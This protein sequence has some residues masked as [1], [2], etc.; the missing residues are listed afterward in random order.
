MQFRKLT[1]DIS[2]RKRECLNLAMGNQFQQFQLEELLKRLEDTKQVT[3]DLEEELTHYPSPKTPSPVNILTALSP[4]PISPPAVGSEVFTLSPEFDLLEEM[5]PPSEFLNI[6]EMSG[7]ESTPLM[8]RLRRPPSPQFRL[9]SSG[10]LGAVRPPSEMRYID[11]MEEESSCLREESPGILGLRQSFTG[12]PKL[13]DISK[14]VSALGTEYPSGGVRYSLKVPTSA[15]ISPGSL[16]LEEN[17]ASPVPVIAQHQPSPR[18]PEESVNMLD[19]I[20]LP[21]ALEDSLD[22]SGSIGIS[23][24]ILDLPQRI[25]SPV[26]VIAQHQ[27]SPL[28]LEGSPGMLNEMRPPTALEDSLELLT[29]SLDSLD[30]QKSV[31]SP[32]PVVA[33]RPTT[34]GHLRESLDNLDSISPPSDLRDSLEISGNDGSPVRAQPAYIHPVKMATG[35]VKNLI[36]FSSPRKPQSNINMELEMVPVNIRESPSGHRVLCNVGLKMKEAVVTKPRWR[37]IEITKHIVRGSPPISETVGRRFDRKYGLFTPKSV[38]MRKFVGVRRPLFGGLQ[39][40]PRIP[41]P[42]PPPLDT[43]IE[44]ERPPGEA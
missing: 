5:R 17:I 34:Y 22:L 40:P 44:W 8:P 16:K 1:E 11:S 29:I 42:R 14:S 38:I 41:S 37:N 35:S 27:A 9:Q 30:L 39:F 43:T 13:V 36:T 7:L 18:W 21:T 32:V 28:W 6:L 2:E 20:S 31:S 24:G 15:T 19:I 23:P 33:Q 10:M 12:T 4:A 3:I 26:P 25:V